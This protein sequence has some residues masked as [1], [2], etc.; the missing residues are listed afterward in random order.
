[1]NLQYLLG[2]LCVNTNVSIIFVIYIIV[3]MNFSIHH[4]NAISG[5]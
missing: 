2:Q 1:M 4:L 3:K 5:C